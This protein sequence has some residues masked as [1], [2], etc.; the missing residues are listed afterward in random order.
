MPYHHTST[1]MNKEPKK[2]NKKTVKPIMGL[3]IQQTK[4]I[5]EH[6]KSHK[7]G[8]NSKHIKNMVKFMKAGD[9]FPTAHKKAVKLDKSP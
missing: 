9:N 4:K 7:N 1:K 6:S 8:M 5:K 3:T 2:E